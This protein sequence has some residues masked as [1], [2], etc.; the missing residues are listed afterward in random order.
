MPVSVHRA[1]VR[2]AAPRLALVALVIIVTT[3][4]I[5][6]APA[7]PAPAQPARGSYEFDLVIDSPLSIS[8]EL[9][10]RAR[11][12][13]TCA[14]VARPVAPM[15]S[16][17]VAVLLSRPIGATPVASEMTAVYSQPGAL[18]DFEQDV[19]AVAAKGFR[20]CGFTYTAP[21]WG[22]SSRYTPVAVFNR[23]PRAA[24][25][26]SYRIIRTEGRGDQWK[27]L[28]KSGADGYRIKTVIARP[29]PEEIVRNGGTSDVLFITEKTADTQPL[30][31]D[32]I[33]AGNGVALEKDFKK[34]APKGFG[35]E[36]LWTGRD[37]VSVLVS[38]PLGSASP[39]GTLRDLK[40]D[41]QSD[42]RVSGLDG[43]LRGMLRFRDG[44]MA[45]YEP[46]APRIEYSVIQGDVQD[47][48]RGIYRV[49]DNQRWLVE[50][51]N[52][53]GKRGYLPW[54]FTW[55]IDSGERRRVDVI[56]RRDPT[57]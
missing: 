21:V 44:V 55:R 52:A 25:V 32:L 16:T 9:R 49:P 35:F 43:A 36:A 26:A 22:P 20:L 12:G 18:V 2:I 15:L 7:P 46:S 28:E 45:V 54:D 40:I 4:L 37:L 19:N 33:F 10:R 23:A 8:S 38:R 57:P 42:V 3:S 14:A 27:V 5:G 11:D 17:N 41:E 39:G 30:E 50:K 6:A 34:K 29:L 51:L 48:D 24:G 53:D 56:L 1:R 31:Y 13:F 47:P